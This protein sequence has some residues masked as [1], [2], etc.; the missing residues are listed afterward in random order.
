[1]DRNEILKTISEV[2][3]S[4]NVCQATKPRRGAQ[5]DTLDLFPIPE[6]L[7]SSISVDLVSMP[8]LHH[9]S[10]KYNSIMVVLCRLTGYIIAVPCNSNLS[11]AE[12]AA[13]LL[14]RMVSF[15]GLPH[16]IFSGHDSILRASFFH[17]L[18]GVEDHKST[19][20]NPK[21]NGRAERAVQSIVQ[22]LQPNHGTKNFQRLVPST[23]PCHLCP[24]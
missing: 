4:C 21:A 18:L 12:L 14:E 24:E 10:Q 9:H 8:E 17:T 15:M 23:P 3:K 6:F 22:S 2:V 19:V 1:M 20:Y 5:P 13:L 11:S 7:F 16:E